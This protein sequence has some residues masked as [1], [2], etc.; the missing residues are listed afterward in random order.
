MW[1]TKQI[2][3]ETLLKLSENWLKFAIALIQSGGG[4]NFNVKKL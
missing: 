2:T 3:D 4:G 1:R